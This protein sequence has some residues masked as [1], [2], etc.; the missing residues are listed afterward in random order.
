M[1]KAEQIAF[2][3]RFVRQYGLLGFGYLA[4]PLIE[5]AQAYVDN[6]HT[7]E[8]CKHVEACYRG[9]HPE[10]LIN[11]PPGT[12]KSVWCSVFAD[13][14][15][16]TWNPGFRMGN[17]SFA[18]KNI[19]R[20]GNKVFA[21][22]TS[23]WYRERWPDVVLDKGKACAAGEFW[24]TAGGLRYSSTVHGQGTGYHFHVRKFDDPIKPADTMGSA[25]AT[26]LEID[27][28]N[29]VWWD[30]TISTRVLD[31]SCPRFLG[32]MQRL[33]EDDLVGYLERK[34]PGVVKLS[35]P[36]RFE[37]SRKC[38]TPIGGDRRTVEGELLF[39]ERF[40]EQYVA[41]LE[42]QLG[43]YARAQL[44]QDPCDP[45]GSVFKAAHMRR[46][47]ELPKF[48]SLILS[49]D[50]TFKKAA[51]SDQVS[52]QVWGTDGRDFYLVENVTD[53]MSFVDTVRNARALVSRFEYISAK[54]IEDT[55][56][57][58]AVIEVLSQAWNG[59]IPV[60][61]EG[62]KV[63]RANSTSH[64]WQAGNVYLPEDDYAPWVPGYVAELLAFP[65]GRFDDQV[66]AT[67]QALIYLAQN[68]ASIWQWLDLEVKAGAVSLEPEGGLSPFANFT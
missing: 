67:T 53:Q 45:E 52:L 16:W 34:A 37:A 6:W 14:W 10:M 42:R 56:N 59:V 32:I 51:G 3:R 29:Q 36:M 68:T 25:M 27:F 65:R 40:P 50:C 39:A 48:T 1:N 18:D 57:G 64:L 21:L 9:T 63:A 66:D 23:E 38:V 62:G 4:W 55:A 13:A 12:G 58:P 46:W 30:G 49:V 47:K 54:L 44:Q 15:A 7:E 2:D 60:T 61:P 33:H 8:V 26:K 17:W 35:L 19:R 31:P 22:V 41:N 28:V 43:I 5:P 20:D 24:T 11:V